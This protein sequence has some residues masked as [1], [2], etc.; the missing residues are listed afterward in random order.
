MS[1]SI[2][3][4]T[5]INNQITLNK[6]SFCLDINMNVLISALIGVLFRHPEFCDH[7]ISIQSQ[8]SYNTYIDEIGMFK[9]HLLHGLVY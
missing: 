9:A 6:I 8:F 5:F 7:N 4:S 2:H 3:R 1:M